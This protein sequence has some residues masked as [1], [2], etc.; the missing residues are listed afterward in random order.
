VPEHIAKIHTL[1]AGETDDKRKTYNQIVEIGLRPSNKFSF[2][3][4][5]KATQVFYNS[6]KNAP[7]VSV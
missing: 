7:R 1:A 5:A 6:F 3:T 2:F 4:R